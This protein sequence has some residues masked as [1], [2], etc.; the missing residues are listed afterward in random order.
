MDYE[1][2]SRFSEQISDHDVS[3]SRL[4]AWKCPLCWVVG[5]GIDEWS[6]HVSRELVSDLGIE[7]IN[8]YV[9]YLSD[10]GR[11]EPVDTF[12]EAELLIALSP[13]DVFRIDREFRFV[14]KWFC[15]SREIR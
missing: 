13:V 7:K 14:S 11:G 10:H 12:L 8:R 5:D 9:P 6:M 3:P 15:P 1:L 2:V 4:G